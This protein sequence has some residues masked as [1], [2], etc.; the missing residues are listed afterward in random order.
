MKIQFVARAA[1]PGIEESWTLLNAASYGPATREA[2]KLCK[3]DDGCEILLGRANTITGAVTVIAKRDMD[4]GG[5]KVV[6][7]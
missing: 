2:Y 1:G 4:R 7:I 5:W 6:G 3:E